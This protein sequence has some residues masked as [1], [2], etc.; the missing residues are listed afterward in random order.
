M[1][2]SVSLNEDKILFQLEEPQYIQTQT[3]S[4]IESQSQ[5]LNL[6]LNRNHPLSRNLRVDSTKSLHCPYWSTT[7]R[8]CA[9]QLLEVAD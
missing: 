9:L 1:L 2:V 4:P 8:N 6:N 5:N 7:I 3:L